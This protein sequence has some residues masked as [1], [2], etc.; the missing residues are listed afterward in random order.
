MLSH[1]RS[2]PS[3]AP[4]LAHGDLGRPLARIGN[5]SVEIPIFRFA[6]AHARR[7]TWF[8]VQRGYPG[9]SG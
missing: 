4:E 2:P 9:L 5:E 8:N 1:A 7:P 3:P 6:M